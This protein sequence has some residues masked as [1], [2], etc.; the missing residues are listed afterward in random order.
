MSVNPGF[1][2]QKFIDYQVSRLPGTAC[3]H[4][5]RGRVTRPVSWSRTLRACST[6][7]AHH[8]AMQAQVGKIKKLR[9]MCDAAGV[10]PWIEVDGGIT[11]ANAHQASGSRV[12]A[13]VPHPVSRWA[14]LV[15]VCNN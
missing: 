7:C 1:G 14:M 4:G 12:N 5:L 10:D 11:P 9:E 3:C 15:A 2:G 6:A 8:G 13:T